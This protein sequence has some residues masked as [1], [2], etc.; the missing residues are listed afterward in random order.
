MSPGRSLPSDASVPVPIRAAPDMKILS[1]C[2]CPPG[3]APTP[4]FT[5]LSDR[6]F[7]AGRPAPLRLLA[8]LRGRRMSGNQQ[9]RVK[10]APPIGLGE[11]LAHCVRE[12][13]QGGDE[14]DREFIGIQV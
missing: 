12:H 1:L 6:L 11:I 4:G 3:G 2:G 14:L 13:R 7:S 9:E 10:Q 5:T 8:S